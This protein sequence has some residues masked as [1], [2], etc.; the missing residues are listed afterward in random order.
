[1]NIYD[2]IKVILNY[3]LRLYIIHTGRILKRLKRSLKPATFTII[4]IQD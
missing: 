3:L 2:K 4:V 1:M